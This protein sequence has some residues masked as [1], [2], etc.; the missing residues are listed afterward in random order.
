MELTKQALE[1]IRFRTK[2]NWYR[3][4]EV[5][6]F[7]E[8]LTVSIDEA[9]RQRDSLNAE[10]RRLRQD[11]EKS[12]TQLDSLRMELTK[13]QALRDE[14]EKAEAPIR[15]APAEPPSG[16]AVHQKRVCEELE[17][18]RDEL[19]EEIK[20]L[21]RFREEFRVSVERDAKTLLEQLQKL[22]SDTL[23]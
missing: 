1:E 8:E 12:G 10:N 18:E 6:A 7:I 15:E 16:T 20:L 9:E 13:L 2:G 19:I 11:L 5:D 4:E 21:R 17:K 14:H 22:P 23:L 3:S